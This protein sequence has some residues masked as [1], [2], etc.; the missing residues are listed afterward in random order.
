MSAAGYHL[1]KIRWQ[2]IGQMRLT[3]LI[4]SMQMCPARFTPLLDPT[5]I[6]V[7][8]HRVGRGPKDTLYSKANS[9]SPYTSDHHTFGMPFFAAK[10][11][12]SPKFSRQ[13]GS[14]MPSPFLST[15]YFPRYEEDEQTNIQK[16]RDGK[17]RG[18]TEEVP[19]K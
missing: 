2:T 4:D 13:P 15:T 19:S 9:G 10:Q 7:P 3:G 5:M 1:W 6:D 16:S 11:L 17:K 18:G 8:T 12:S 14:E